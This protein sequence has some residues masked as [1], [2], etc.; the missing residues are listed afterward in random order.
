MRDR[1]I[2]DGRTFEQLCKNYEDGF[3]AWRCACCAGEQG[4]KCTQCVHALGWHFCEEHPEAD[5]GDAVWCAGSLHNGKFD[6]AA[7]LWSMAR[8]QVP[9]HVMKE[10]LEEY[11]Q[12][13]LLD[14]DEKDAYTEIFE[15]MRGVVRETNAYADNSSACHTAAATE[16]EN[17]MMTEEELRAELDKREHMLQ[18]HHGS[19]GVCTDQWRVYSEIVE[20]IKAQESSPQG[21]WPI[22]KDRDRNANGCKLVGGIILV[23][24]R[25]F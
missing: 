1:E 4:S 8:R 10:R 7:T 11:R 16:S 18:E 9:L 20:G 14:A 15:Q 23:G 19:E 5:G 21:F 2:V 25:H 12:Q 13:G 24:E 6:V 3:E 22:A 17:R